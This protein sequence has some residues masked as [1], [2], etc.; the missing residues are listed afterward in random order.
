MFFK[1]NVIVVK[2]CCNVFNSEICNK[3]TNESKKGVK[4]IKLKC[5]H[6]LLLFSLLKN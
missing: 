1:T 3:T 2:A 5:L 4:M 6:N